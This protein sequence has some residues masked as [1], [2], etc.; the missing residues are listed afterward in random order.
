MYEPLTG[1]DALLVLTDWDEFKKADLKKVKE[2]LT[3]P[4]IVDGRN[5]YNKETLKEL[6]IE[7]VSIGR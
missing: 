6:E 1:S 2:L 5:I 3:I 4:I 7:Y